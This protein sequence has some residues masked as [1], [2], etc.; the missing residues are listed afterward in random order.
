MNL[1]AETAYVREHIQDLACISTKKTNLH[2]KGSVK[3]AD[4]FGDIKLQKTAIME[5]I[6]IEENG[7]VLKKKGRNTLYI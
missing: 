7:V 4:L 3:V 6:Q 1:L 2:L 5:F